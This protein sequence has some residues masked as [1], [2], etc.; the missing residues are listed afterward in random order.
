LSSKSVTGDGGGAKGVVGG[1]SGG[2]GGG[3]V[4]GRE[5]NDGALGGVVREFEA[6]LKS[7][8][9]CVLMAVCR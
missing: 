6:A 1:D 9:R 2:G 3:G 5:G 4:E 8:G 7:R